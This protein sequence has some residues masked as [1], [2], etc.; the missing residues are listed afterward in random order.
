MTHPLLAIYMAQYTWEA[1]ARALANVLATG[2]HFTA[3]RDLCVLTL[4]ANP[5]L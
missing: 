5:V 2:E 3:L 4:N 1:A